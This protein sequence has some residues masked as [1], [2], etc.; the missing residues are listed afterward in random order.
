MQANETLL[1]MIRRQAGRNPQAIALMAPGRSPLSYQELVGQIEAAALQFTRLNVGPKDRVVLALPNGPE[2]A[3]AF[4]AVASIA[5]CAPLNPDYSSREFERY[6]S[7]LRASHVM[8]EAGG[9]S[10]VQAAAEALGIP[11][12]PIHPELNSAAG[13]FSLSQDGA[14]G[15]PVQYAGPEDIALLMH[16]SGTTGHAK[17][18]P[19][20]HTN[21]VASARST[22]LSLE[23]VPEDRGMNILPLYHIHGL[24]GGVV[25]CLAAGASVLCTPGLIADQ[26][27]NW[28]ME[29]APTW[30]TAAPPMHQA[31][32][33]CAARQPDLARQ[34][35]LRFIRSASAALPPQVGQ[36]LEE[37]FHVPFIEAYGM[38]EA[39]PMIASNPLPPR[40][41]Q[42]GSVGLPVG[43][44]VAILDEEG[45]PLPAGSIGE[46]VVRGTNVMHGYLD[47]PAANASAF[48]NGWLRTGDLGYRDTQGYLFIRGRLKEMI[49]RGGEKIVPTEI[50]DVLLQHPAVL[51]AV[52]FAIPHPSLGEQP[53]AAVVLRPGQNITAREIRTFIAERL[54]AFKVPRKVVFV[55]E[56]P[57]GPTGKLQRIGLAETLKFELAEGKGEIPE[58]VPPR[59]LLESRLV[60]I[61]RTALRV[62]QLS[63]TDDFFELGGDSI[64]AVSMTHEIEKEFACALPE[65]ALIEHGT[66]AEIAELIRSGSSANSRSVLIPMH[67]H[68]AKAPVFLVPGG[69]GGVFYL[70]GLVEYLKEDHPAYG[71]QITRPDL[72][73]Q[74]LPPVQDLVEDY[75]H[76]IREFYPGGP[77][78]LLGHSSGGLIAFEIACQLIQAGQQVAM[79]GL[80]DTYPPGMRPRASFQE[81][82]TIHSKNLF[83]AAGFKERSAYFLERSRRLF[84]RMI[85]ST[86]F[87]QPAAR[88]GLV[89]T[90]RMTLSMLLQDSYRPR[91]F[92]G[93]LTVF[94]VASRPW[95]SHG[96]PLAAWS[97][98]ARFV[99]FVDV[100]GTHWTLLSEPHVHELADRI[101]TLLD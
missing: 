9:P 95:Y 72:R 14:G 10:R 30:Y 11:V 77:Y 26:V 60:K 18:V 25:S 67:P 20:T 3:V 22:A 4:L 73:T 70:R 6:L 23:L 24:I 65:A 99:N 54:S 8:V 13:T 46:I 21:L 84:L 35:H 27:L 33:E 45:N 50:D 91:Y 66:I 12:I 64:T 31:I 41:H 78:L 93:S 37:I 15:G 53:A 55:P 90:D 88:A 56:I 59:D 83:N 2:M 71:L 92:D 58:F 44:E 97:E 85:R 80:F 38:T 29:F 94:R 19:L 61:W 17:L 32:L 69:M 57:K 75:I 62:G 40:R 34:I 100:P 48:I 39:A 79:L 42:F 36:A 43:C 47:D 28:M 81:R 89:P 1:G 87:L 16:T 49:N 86:P 101:N 51:Q 76:A 68:G 74:R 96:D 5:H 63:V 52:T 82:V 7:D 98:Y